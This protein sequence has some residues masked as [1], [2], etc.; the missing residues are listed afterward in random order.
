MMLIVSIIAFQSYCKARILMFSPYVVSFKKSHWG[1]LKSKNIKGMLGNK[2]SPAVSVACHWTC[3]LFVNKVQVDRGVTL[4]VW[5][6]TDFP[7]QLNKNQI[8]KY[9]A[10]SYCPGGPVPQISCLFSIQLP[11]ALVQ[12]NQKVLL[13]SNNNTSDFFLPSA[14]LELKVL[15]PSSLKV[16]WP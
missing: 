6:K 5:K 9:D 7:Q 12:T 13:V 10:Q 1:D 3:R 8:V 11:A 14:A 16:R 15:P 4:R 2:L